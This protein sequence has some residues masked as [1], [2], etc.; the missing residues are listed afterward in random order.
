[1]GKNIYNT[2]LISFVTYFSCRSNKQK[3]IEP[4]KFLLFFLLVT[5]LRLRTFCLKKNKKTHKYTKAKTN[6]LNYVF[7]SRKKKTID[8]ILLKEITSLSICNNKKGNIL[9][10]IITLNH[11]LSKTLFSCC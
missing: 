2:K 4:N 10:K 9:S 5:K 6:V 3:T 7:L 1:M 8:I 11:S